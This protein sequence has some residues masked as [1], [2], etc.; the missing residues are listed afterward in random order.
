MPLLAKRVYACCDAVMVTWQAG[1]FENPSAF[2]ASFCASSRVIIG[3]IREQYVDLPESCGRA[4]V[5]DG[6][7]LRRLALGVAGEPEL[8]PVCRAR[9]AIARLPEVGRA[10]LIGHAR[11]HLA[12]LAA[13]DFPEC[14]AAELEVVAL[15]ID[16]IIACAIDQDA[17]L[18]TADQAFERGLSG[19]GFEPHVGH[20]LERN[21]RPRIGLAAAV[22]F[23]V[24]HQVRLLARGL[25]VAEDALIDDG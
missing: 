3:L 10:A 22:R 9:R 21:R 5:A 4:S 8:A 12:L 15:L 20:A 25:V 17:V 7:D 13:F 2:W 19:T 11:N 18:D 1:N 14:I 24:A 6:V 23:L 16:R